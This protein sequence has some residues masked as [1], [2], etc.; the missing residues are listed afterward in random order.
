MRNCCDLNDCMHAV[1]IDKLHALLVAVC[2]CLFLQLFKLFVD[3]VAWMAS[4]N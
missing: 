2:S 3:V 1:V 4:V